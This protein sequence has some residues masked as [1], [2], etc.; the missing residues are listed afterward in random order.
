MHASSP[1]SLLL[2][3]LLFLTW[4]E[5]SWVSVAEMVCLTCLSHFSWGWC[6]SCSIAHFLDQLRML[7]SLPKKCS[8][9]IYLRSTREAENPEQPVLW[10]TFLLDTEYLTPTAALEDGCR[11][12]ALV[13]QDPLMTLSTYFPRR[14]SCNLLKKLKPDWPRDSV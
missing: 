7:I 10:T 1:R 5:N 13:S 3:T 12:P 4:G 2:L 14:G 8:A 9:F 11:C 6:L